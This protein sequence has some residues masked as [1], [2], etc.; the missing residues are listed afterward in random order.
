MA[1]FNLDPSEGPHAGANLT[2]RELEFL[3][4]MLAV[5]LAIRLGKTDY[6]QRFHDIASHRIE[7]EDMVTD[8]RRQRDQMAFVA[9]VTS[10]LESLPVLED[11]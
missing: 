8:W 7:M 6:Q 1:T 3:Q 2:D 5:E 4:Q 9:S 11:R 10:D